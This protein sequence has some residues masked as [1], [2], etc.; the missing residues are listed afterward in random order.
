[1]CGKKVREFVYFALCDQ[2]CCDP[3]ISVSD[4]IQILSRRGAVKRSSVE[5]L[6][7]RDFFKRNLNLLVWCLLSIVQ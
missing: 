1:M 7:T 2:L 6:D 4:F 3:A 5:I